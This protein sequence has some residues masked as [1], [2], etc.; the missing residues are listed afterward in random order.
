MNPISP[1]EGE[2]GET[3]KPLRWITLAA[4]VAWLVALLVAGTY[5][6]LG[7]LGYNGCW[8]D[9]TGLGIGVLLT[10]YGVMLPLIILE[11]HV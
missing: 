10:G 8:S 3:F 9:A 6:A 7:C 2:G 5:G 1:T 4:T 11:N